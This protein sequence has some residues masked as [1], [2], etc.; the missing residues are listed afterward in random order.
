M[1]KPKKI[2]SGIKNICKNK[3][4]EAYWKKIKLSA[5]DILRLELEALNVDF[6]AHTHVKVIR[7]VHS[8]TRFAKTEIKK[9]QGKKEKIN[10]NYS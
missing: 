4:F 8:L 1:K 9:L 7:I 5:A 6:L 10:E 3:K 2:V